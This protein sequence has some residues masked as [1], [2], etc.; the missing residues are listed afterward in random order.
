VGY[1]SGAFILLAWHPNAAVYKT[2]INRKEALTK[3]SGRVH[4]LQ[5]FLEEAQRRHVQADRADAE[6]A[7]LEP[8][9]LIGTCS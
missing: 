5:R 2:R 9:H 3:T 8:V 4:S 1:H 6:F 7:L